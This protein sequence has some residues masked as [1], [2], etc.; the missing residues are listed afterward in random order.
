MALHP[1]LCA[2]VSVLPKEAQRLWTQAKNKGVPEKHV[3][4]SNPWTASYRLYI[5]FPWDLLGPWVHTC[6]LA[7]MPTST[8]ELKIK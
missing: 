2:Q 5:A 6:A 4:S 3:A 1:L 7:L 8:S